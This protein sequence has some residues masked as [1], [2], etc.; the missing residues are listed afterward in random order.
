MIDMGT[1]VYT[2]KGNKPYTIYGVSGGFLLLG[3]E[4]P[5]EGCAINECELFKT[6]EEMEKHIDENDPT[7]YEYYVATWINFH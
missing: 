5:H 2:E 4:Y 6:K 7:M 1:E 3:L